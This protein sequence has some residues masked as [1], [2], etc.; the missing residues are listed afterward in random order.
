MTSIISCESQKAWRE[1]YLSSY[2]HCPHSVET[3]EIQGVYEKGF[4]VSPL[5]W[6]GR[7]KQ[8]DFNFCPQNSEV[9][10]LS[11]VIKHNICVSYISKTLSFCNTLPQTK[12]VL[13]WMILWLELSKIYCL[14]QN[15]FQE[16]IFFHRNFSCKS[17]NL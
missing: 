12:S 14:Q 7:L 2:G 10:S 16:I 9:F 4:P 13:K 11:S 1:S 15:A 8:V 6:E 3:V 17:T 5:S